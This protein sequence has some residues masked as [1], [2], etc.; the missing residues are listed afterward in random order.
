M[1]VAA[2]RAERRVKVKQLADKGWANTRIAEELGSTP[3]TVK[4]DIAWLTEHEGYERPS[5]VPK[6]SAKKK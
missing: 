6:G 3:S 1:A 4:S 5:V 2:K